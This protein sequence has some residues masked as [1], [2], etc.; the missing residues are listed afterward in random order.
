MTKTPKFLFHDANRNSSNQL[1]KKGRRLMPSQMKNIVDVIAERYKVKCDICGIVVSDLDTDMA[2]DPFLYPL[3][4]SARKD[5]QVCNFC[6]EA[7]Q[8]FQYEAYVQRVHKMNEDKKKQI[9]E[10][11]SQP[12]QEII[13]KNIELI[14]AY[15][16][17]IKKEREF[18]AKYG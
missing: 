9:E 5:T 13:T 1:F 6:L 12:L 8:Q 15:E 4:A 14:Q 2:I 16:Y 7:E 3:E 10:Y 17:N 11:Y 18:K